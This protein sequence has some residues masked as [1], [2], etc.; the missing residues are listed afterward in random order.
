MPTNKIDL[1]GGFA[2][3]VSITPEEHPE[4]RA[5]RLKT[6][7]RQSLIEDCKG[8]AVFVILLLAIIAVGLIAAYE[9]LWDHDA[10][11]ETKRWGMTMLSALVSGGV[12][13]VVGRKIGSK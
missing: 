9:G 2:G 6:E 13:F 11:P 8:V 10:S 5:T 1:T 3:E 12:S 7:A 4:Q